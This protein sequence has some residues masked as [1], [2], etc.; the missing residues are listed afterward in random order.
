MRRGG[1]RDEQ[2]DLDRLFWRARVH[3][4]AGACCVAVAAMDGADR[5]GPR[6]AA[7]GDRADRVTAPGPVSDQPSEKGLLSLRE[8]TASIVARSSS[9]VFLATQRAV[10]GSMSKCQAERSAAIQIC[11]AARWL[12]TMYFTP[13]ENSSVRIPLCRSTSSPS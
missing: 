7:R 3:E 2:G 8:T 9:P 10:L 4:R 1:R 6:G 12:L 13:S 11:R 5:R